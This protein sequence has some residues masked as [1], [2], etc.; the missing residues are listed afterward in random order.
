MSTNVLT[1]S[2]LHGESVISNPA[3]ANLLSIAMYFC[4]LRIGFQR[5]LRCEIQH[6]GVVG[7]YVNRTLIMYARIDPLTDAQTRYSP[8]KPRG[9]RLGYCSVNSFD[10]Q[11]ADGVLVTRGQRC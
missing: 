10:L 2:L 4:V 9:K 6:F 3:V 11:K 8:D 1:D 5:I 7:V